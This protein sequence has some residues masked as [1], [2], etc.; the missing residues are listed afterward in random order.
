MDN[1]IVN[2]VVRRGRQFAEFIDGKFLNN[3]VKYNKTKWE[4]SYFIF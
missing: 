4:K 2:L 1:Q 3:F